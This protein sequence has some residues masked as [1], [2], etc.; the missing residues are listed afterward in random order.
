MQNR[1]DIS[2]QH[3]SLK[4]GRADFTTGETRPFWGEIVTAVADLDQSIA[5]LILTPKASVPTNPEKGVD[6]DRVIDKHAELGIP[7]LTQDIW[8]QLTIWEPRIVV[9]DVKVEMSDFSH[10]S[11][12]IFWRPIE[13][14]LDDLLVTEVNFSVGNRD[15]RRRFA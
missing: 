5:N 3:W 2:F 11:V 9:Q 13:S 4:V 7:L 15:D 6:Y 1:Y 12:Q 8:D 10:F 14:V